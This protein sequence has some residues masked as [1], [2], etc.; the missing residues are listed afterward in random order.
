MDTTKESGRAVCAWCEKDLGPR[1][2]IEPGETTH[3][4]CKPCAKR[5]FDDAPMT[6]ETVS[7]GA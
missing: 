4:I 3:G 2:G 1:E 7:A 5:L 6:D